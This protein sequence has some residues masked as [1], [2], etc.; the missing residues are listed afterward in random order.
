MDVVAVFQADEIAA[1]AEFQAAPGKGCSA[2]HRLADPGGVLQDGR[3]FA[4]SIYAGQ[5]DFGA[6][7]P[8]S[9]FKSASLQCRGIF[10]THGGQLGA[11]AHQDEPAAGG[12][13][14]V[15]YQVVQKRR[16]GI[17]ERISRPVGEHRGLVDQKYGVFGFVG[18]QD[19]THPASAAGDDGVDLFVD[20][21]GGGAGV[22][23]HY[24]G[25]A[26]GG[27]H[28]E[29]FASGVVQGTYQRGDQARF[30]CSGI[31][32]QDEDPLTAVGI[33]ELGQGFHG[34]TLL[35]GGLVGE[36]GEDALEKNRIGHRQ[37]FCAK[38]VKAGRGDGGKRSFLFVRCRGASCLL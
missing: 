21:A 25:G 14:H 19:K 28:Q 9:V 12:V 2:F 27:S 38:V 34:R 18:A 36:V 6:V 22:T 1:G 32:A 37:G 30:T 10:V 20:G 35:R 33:Q 31:S 16:R 23:G 11:V 15:A 13:K 24:F 4:L 26:P 5:I 17:G 3:L 7:K 8:V 29:G